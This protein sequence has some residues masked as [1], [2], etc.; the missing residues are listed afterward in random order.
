MDF[1][2]RPRQ[3]IPRDEALRLVQQLYDALD[4]AD[5]AN[6]PQVRQACENQAHELGRRLIAGTLSDIQA[7]RNAAAA[8]SRTMIEPQAWHEATIDAG[9]KAIDPAALNTPAGTM[10]A[11]NMLCRT[12]L[13]HPELLPPGLA[14][15]T[16][17][18]L[19]LNLLGDRDNWLT[20]RAG[21]G[22][23]TQL[24][25]F[26]QL[27]SVYY[28]AGYHLISSL[29]RAAKALFPE[30]PNKWPALEQFR[31]RH[32]DLIGACE[33]AKQ[34]G[35]A[36]I[37]AG[38]PYCNPFAVDYTMKQLEVLGQTPRQSKTTIKAKKKTIPQ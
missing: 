28:H 34:T 29:E 5:A 3:R 13:D 20:R 24:V 2:D 12:L 4:A 14:H 32:N 10:Q 18:A 22:G 27:T 26:A 21:G 38:R 36:D 37:T 16:A 25:S 1:T 23:V 15:H 9:H 6:D 35:I 17:L 31:T 33:F 19:H 8:I 7:R 30:D 11:K